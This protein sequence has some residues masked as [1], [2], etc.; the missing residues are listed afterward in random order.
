MRDAG[1]DGMSSAL[2]IA[3]LAVRMY[4]EAH[5]RPTHVNQLQAAEMLRISTP[6]VRKL[7]NSGA[8]KLNDCGLIPIESV[9]RARA[10]KGA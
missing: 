4:A 7:I 3:A 9:D 6:T 10:P 2:E 8:I 5:P 1:T